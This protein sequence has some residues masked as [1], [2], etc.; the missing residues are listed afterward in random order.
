MDKIFMLRVETCLDGET[1]VTTYP[2]ISKDGAIEH[3]N[4]EA[5]TLLSETDCTIEEKKDDSIYAENGCGEYVYIQVTE[6]KL[7]K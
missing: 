5:D 7:L 2:H 6:E 3:L 1:V 4:E